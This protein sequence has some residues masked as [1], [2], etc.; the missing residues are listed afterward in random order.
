MIAGVSEAVEAVQ[1]V[2]EDL[3][4]SIN[5]DIK[6][7]LAQLSTA[8]GNTHIYTHKGTARQ[9]AKLFVCACVRVCVHA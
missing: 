3:G 5:D 4:C 8:T 9:R 7:L 1:G 6:L 2:A